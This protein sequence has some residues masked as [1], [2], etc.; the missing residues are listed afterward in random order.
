MRGVL[1]RFCG[2]FHWGRGEEGEEG[3]GVMSEEMLE[4]GSQCWW[5][6]EGVEGVEGE[7]WR[8]GHWGAQ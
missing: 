6:V 7:V 1:V 3:E 2:G 4:V 8:W 5:G